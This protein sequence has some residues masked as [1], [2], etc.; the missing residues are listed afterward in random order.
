MMTKNEQH[1]EERLI[2]AA[3]RALM[4]LAQYREKHG[5]SAALADITVTAR[6]SGWSERATKQIG[7]RMLAAGITAQAARAL[8]ADSERR[9]Q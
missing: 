8:F 4:R 3:A 1:Q 7:R 6:I 5:Q 2:R 9:L